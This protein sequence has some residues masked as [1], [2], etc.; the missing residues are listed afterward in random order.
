[1]TDAKT[2]PLTCQEMSRLAKRLNASRRDQKLTK[3][4]G[5]VLINFWVTESDAM[6]LRLMFGYREEFANNVRTILIDA[7][8]HKAHSLLR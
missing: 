7:A 4:S 6:L 2:K 1:M 8:N 3:R 5:A